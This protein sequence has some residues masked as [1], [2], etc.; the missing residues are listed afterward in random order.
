MKNL[1]YAALSLIMLI[2]ATAQKVVAAASRPEAKFI[3]AKTKRSQ[4]AAA[5]EGAALFN[6]SDLP[7]MINAK[8]AY[9]KELIDNAAAAGGKNEEAEQ[10]W[11]DW[12]TAL[13]EGRQLAVY[14]ATRAATIKKAY[15]TYAEPFKAWVGRGRKRITEKRKK[16]AAEAEKRTKAAAA[17]AKAVLKRRK[18]AE[19]NDVVGRRTLA[20][21]A[22]KNLF[23]ELTGRAYSEGEE[24]EAINTIENEKD[25]MAMA[26]LAQQ[27]QWLTINHFNIGKQL[28]QIDGA[29]PECTQLDITRA[30]NSLKFILDRLAEVRKGPSIA[31]YKM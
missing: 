6:A 11:S 8:I 14:A 23:K 21:R 1:K 2:S 25:L 7:R 28:H 4:V 24:M 16:A 22:Y 27:R 5:A 30:E 20:S 19:H 26:D 17:E 31:T 18:L 12:V 3:S 10:K 9:Y 15:T 29:E 13:E